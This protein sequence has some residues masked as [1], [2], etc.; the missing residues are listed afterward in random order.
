MTGFAQGRYNFK[1]FSLFVS[2]KSY[3]NRYLETSLRGSG[4]TAASEKHVRALLK[5]R[6]QR[7]KVEVVLDLFPEGTGQWR[8]QLNAPLLEEVLRRLAPLQQKFA[9]AAPLDSLLKMPALF[10]LDFDPERIGP[11]GQAALRRAVAAV[12]AAFLE[13]RRREGLSIR[14]DLLASLALIDGHVRALRAREKECEREAVRRYRQRLARLLGDLPVDERRVAQE[15]VIAADKAAIAEEVNRL[16]THARRLRRLL[17]GR[18]PAAKGKEADF[19][20]QEMQRET[21]TIAAKTDS[22]EIQRL[23]LLIRREIEKIRQQAQ[24]VE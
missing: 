2:F 18:Q 3:N 20:V 5:G 1:D 15:A 24:N 19:L 6:L 9:A 4:V 11:R 14:R 22:L 8:I 13:S 21:H 17:N 7:G 16:Q 12:F 10:R 23:I